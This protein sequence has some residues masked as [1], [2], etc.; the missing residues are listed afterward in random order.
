MCGI[1]AIVGRTGVRQDAVRRMLDLMAHRG[2]DGEGVWSGADGRV[3]FGHRRLAVIDPTLGGAQPMASADGTVVVTFNGEIYNYRE[4]RDRL[5]AE[6]TAFRSDSDTEVLLQAYLRWGEA[7]LGELNGMF[8]FCLY[9]ARQR[10]VIC[11]RDRFGE[12]PLL[13]A[14]TPGY[15]AFASEYKALLALDGV[16]D[17]IDE[18]RLLGFLDRPRQGL[19]DGAET[20]FAG[21]RQVRGGEV[22][23]LDVDTLAVSVRRYWSLVPGCDGAA[24]AP[25]EAAARFKEL[26]IDSVRLRLRSDV[27]LG[28]CL[29]G[30]LDSSSIVCLS[31]ALIGDGRPYHVFVGRF[32]GSPADEG[33]YADQVVTATGSTAHEVVPDGDGFLAALEDF[34]RLNELPVGSASQFAQWR[35]F[36]TAKNAG[37]TVLLD[38]QGGD[39][40]LGGYEQYF[41][42]YLASLRAAGEGA[43]A[44]AEEAAIRARYPDALPDA[45][46]RLKRS[47]PRGAKAWLARASGKGSDFRFGVRVAVADEAPGGGPA[48]MDPLRGALYSDCFEGFLS[49]LLR[50]G[51][52]NSM[53][54]SREVRL[55]FLDHR[56]AEFVFSLGPGHVMG[57]AR[58]KRLLRDAMTGVLPDGIVTRWNKQGFLPPQDDWMDGALGRRI[59]ALFH[60]PAFAARG[61]WHVPWWQGALRRFRAGERHLANTLWKPFM[62]EAW[63]EHFVAPVRAGGRV[64]VL[65]AE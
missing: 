31:R 55:P 53:A 10:R 21:I 4:L 24:L 48:G 62:A 11:A 12:K 16:D 34:V 22:L 50:Y 49:A 13:F 43:R 39:E 36:E 46:Q 33:A 2:P 15:V 18:A 28:S 57:E 7:A 52:R 64:A 17:G 61:W 42:P 60:S 63:M 19:D 20:A 59:D 8:A 14:A 3:V 27:A 26:L 47:L 9:D 25:A 51:D 29:S 56:I 44:A 54:H 37:I 1:A 38:G 5:K 23:T 32:P 35:V 6:G 40:I 45:V 65:E 30:G 58:T 41:G